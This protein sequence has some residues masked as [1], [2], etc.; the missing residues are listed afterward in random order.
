MVHSELVTKF[1]VCISNEGY[2]AGLELRKLYQVLPDEAGV[3][4]GC[5]RVLDESGEDYLYPSDFFA[6]LELPQATR[7]SLLALAA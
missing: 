3:R 5:L 2:P 7:D 1:M 6:E 4:L